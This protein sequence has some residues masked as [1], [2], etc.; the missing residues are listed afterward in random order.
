MDN[1]FVSPACPDES[2]FGKAAVV[3]HWGA[4]TNGY[5]GNSHPSTALINQYILDL[6]QGGTVYV[7][8]NLQQWFLPGDKQATA[9]VMDDASTRIQ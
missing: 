1:C 9:K 7:G 6:K 8:F 3:S 4:S 5:W 2:T